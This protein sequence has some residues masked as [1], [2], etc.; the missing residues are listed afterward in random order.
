[1]RGRT[2]MDD[3]LSEGEDFE[4]YYLQYI[5]YIKFLYSQ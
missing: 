4:Q 1:M 3:K 2:V 5:V